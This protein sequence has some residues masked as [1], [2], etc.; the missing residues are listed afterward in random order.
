MFV[1]IFLWIYESTA[2]VVDC[3]VC[4]AVKKVTVKSQVCA[5]SAQT[6]SAN[7]P[8]KM[9]EIK[10]DIKIKCKILYVEQKG[11]TKWRE[12]ICRDLTTNAKFVISTTYPYFYETFK[13]SNKG[14]DLEFWYHAGFRQ[15]INKLIEFETELAWNAVAYGPLLIKSDDAFCTWLTEHHKIHSEHE[16][17]DFANGDCNDWENEI[18][19]DRNTESP[20]KEYI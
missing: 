6:D 19:P 18:F 4:T 5:V 9:S 2:T 1:N 14:L 8:L 10:D 17:C 20:I 11:D 15:V 13:Q 12:F 7:Q 3:V 16:G